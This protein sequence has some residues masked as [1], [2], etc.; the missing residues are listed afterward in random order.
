[1]RCQTFFFS[2]FSRP[3]AGLATV[4]CSFFG[5][6]T[7]MLNVTNNNNNNNNNNNKPLIPPKRFDIFSPLTG[8]CSEGL[9]AFGFFFKQQQQQ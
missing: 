3:Q 1:M 7:N 9:D 4:Q 2:L 8:G 5:L 6:A